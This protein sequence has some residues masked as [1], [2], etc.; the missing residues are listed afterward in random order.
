MKFVENEKGYENET[1]NRDELI[2][3]ASETEVQSA[4]SLLAKHDLGRLTIKEYRG[5]V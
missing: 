2:F 1:N 4:S 3:S 5:N